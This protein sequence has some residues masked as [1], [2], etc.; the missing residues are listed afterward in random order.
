MESELIQETRAWLETQEENGNSKSHK[1]AIIR[2]SAPFGLF[3]TYIDEMGV[4]YEY[5]NGKLES[6]EYDGK[7]VDYT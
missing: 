7:S 1:A 6:I 4:R 5:T 3:A 2:S